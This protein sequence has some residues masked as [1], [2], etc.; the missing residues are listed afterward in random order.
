MLD[1]ADPEMQSIGEGK[2]K[3][4]K[5]DWIS[6]FKNLISSPVCCK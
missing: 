3:E 1:P 4:N 2:Q 5:K 6:D